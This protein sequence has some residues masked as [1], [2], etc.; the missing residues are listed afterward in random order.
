M[1]WKPEGQPIE[2]IMISHGNYTNCAFTGVLPEW[3]KCADGDC[4]EINAQSWKLSPGIWKLLVQPMVDID[5]SDG[6]DMNGAMYKLLSKDQIYAYTTSP[7]QGQFE[8]QG[9]PLPP[10]DELIERLR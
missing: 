9:L 1:N 3:D 6:Y 5:F 10:F 8:P 2:V 7:D 4:I